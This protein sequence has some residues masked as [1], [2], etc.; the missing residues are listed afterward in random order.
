MPPRD[1]RQDSIAFP[2]LTLS[3]TIAC[4]AGA[5]AFAWAGQVPPDVPSGLAPGASY[6]LVFV[7]S[8]STAASS[9][10][11]STYNTLATTDGNPLDPFTTWS[12]IV[13]TPTTDAINNIACSPS[14]ANVPIYLVNGTEVASS[15]TT[16]A[17]GLF[18]GALLHAIDLTQTG[19][20]APVNPTFNNI[21][22]WTGSTSAGTAASLT[23]GGPL[24]PTGSYASGT[25]HYPRTA[26]EYGLGSAAGAPWIAA[27]PA[28]KSASYPVY[29]ISGALT[30]PADVPEPATI[31][32]L[33][34]AAAGLGAVRR[35]RVPPA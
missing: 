9:S 31:A 13:S 17:G 23:N 22:V 12:A 18:S 27:G 8:G 20:A 1:G 25:Q 3:L 21:K 29:A 4:A 32:L 14:C 24:G 10:Q 30:A 5:P 19:A 16:S 33:A 11:V 15:A 34:A 35:R 7:T 28:G 6:R 2:R 26:A